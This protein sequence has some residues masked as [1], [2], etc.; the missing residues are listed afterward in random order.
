MITS[1]VGGVLTD[2][3]GVLT[4]DD[5]V[6]KMSVVGNSENKKKETWQQQF[7]LGRTLKIKKGGH[8]MQIK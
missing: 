6:L 7:E 1:V 4:D 8:T 2:V 5:G 3:G